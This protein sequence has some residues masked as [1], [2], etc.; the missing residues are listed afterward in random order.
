MKPTAVTVDGIMSQRTHED[1]AATGI[2]RPVPGRGETGGG[3]AVGV[4][5]A[6]LVG[7]ASTVTI[8]YELLS[9]FGNRPK[10]RRISAVINRGERDCASQL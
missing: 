5:L 6:E 1:A 8:D 2:Q 10:N 3:S 7:V 4:P 9:V